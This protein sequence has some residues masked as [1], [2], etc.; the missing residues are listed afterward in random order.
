LEHGELMAQDQDLDLVGG[1]GS[2]VQDHPAQDPGEH[3]VDQPQRH[4]SIMSDL[5]TN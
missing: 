5:G 3:E 1:V 2:E 4:R